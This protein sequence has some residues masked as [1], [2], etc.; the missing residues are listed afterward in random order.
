M[1]KSRDDDYKKES[2]HEKQIHSSPSQSD[3]V[4]ESNLKEINDDN[5]ITLSTSEKL[6]DEN[7]IH[8]HSNDNTDNND[9][10]N[11]LNQDMYEVNSNEQPENDQDAESVHYTNDDYE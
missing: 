9:D 3:Q 6:D 7:Q 10:K 2:S 1:S 5:N 4:K 11:L 8:S